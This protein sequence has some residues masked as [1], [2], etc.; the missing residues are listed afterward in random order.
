MCVLALP[1]GGAVGLLPLFPQH[2]LS[3]TAP[4]S[5]Q[6]WRYSATVSR[7]NVKIS[8]VRVTFTLTWY[9]SVA[10]L[11]GMKVIHEFL[12]RDL[13]GLKQTGVFKEPVGDLKLI[14]VIVRKQGQP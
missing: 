8:D 12:H 11:K 1:L 5:D 9:V 4:S 2:K 6:L 7:T 3:V 13:E 10:I 14:K